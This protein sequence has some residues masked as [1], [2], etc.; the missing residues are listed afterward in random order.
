MLNRASCSPNPPGG[1]RDTRSVVPP[2]PAN[3]IE[4]LKQSVHC[5][6]D[7]SSGGVQ[8]VSR[9]V[10]LAGR[11]PFNVSLKPVGRK[12]SKPGR[13]SRMTEC[14]T[15]GSCAVRPAESAAPLVAAGLLFLTLG[16]ADREA[17]SP[18]SVVAR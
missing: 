1:P 18:P 7:K 10:P 8:P 3:L 5:R 13:H 9:R 11:H 16:C 17:A 4:Y 12:A 2:S 6:S 15:L 14:F